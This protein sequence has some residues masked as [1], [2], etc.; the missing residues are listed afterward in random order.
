MPLKVPDEEFL[1]KSGKR[2]AIIQGHLKA[3]VHGEKKTGLVLP[4]MLDWAAKSLGYIDGGCLHQRSIERKHRYECSGYNTEIVNNDVFIVKNC[5]VCDKRFLT[6]MEDKY[7]CSNSCSHSTEESKKNFVERTKN[8]QLKKQKQTQENQ[9][10]AYLE[11]KQSLKRDPKKSE[12]VKKCKEKNIPHRTR[13]KSRGGFSPY[14]LHSFSHL[15]EFASTFNH[16]VVKVEFLE[17]NDPRGQTR[18]L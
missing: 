1:S 4:E 18:R 5:R 14:V 13:T 7:T 2:S 11:L 17:G 9:I 6:K 15:K 3:S 12:W 10:S 8:G 16:R